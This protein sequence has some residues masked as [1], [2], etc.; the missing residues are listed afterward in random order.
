MAGIVTITITVIAITTIIV[1]TTAT[2]AVNAKGPTTSHQQ[3]IPFI[4]SCYCGTGLS[5]KCP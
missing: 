3:F 2:I 5:V 4:M 1:I